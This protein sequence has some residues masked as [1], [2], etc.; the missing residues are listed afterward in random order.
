V[1]TPLYTRTPPDLARAADYGH[2]VC[3]RRPD[4][5]PATAAPL[6]PAANPNTTV[7]NGLDEGDRDWFRPESALPTDPVHVIDACFQAYHKFSLVR[8]IIDLMADFTAKG[9][10]V[11]NR[12]VR[13]QKVGR[14][15]LKRVNARDRSERI[16]H[17]LYLAGTAPLKRRLARLPDGFKPAAVRPVVKSPLPPGQIPVGYDVLDPRTLRLP[18]EF[19]PGQTPDLSGYAVGPPAAGRRLFAWLRPA[20]QRAAVDPAGDAVRLTAKDNV[21][22]FYKRADHQAVPVP[23]TYSVLRDLRTLGKLK[24]ADEMAA[25]GAVTRTRIWTLGKD[26]DDPENIIY[27]TREMMARLNDLVTQSVNGGTLDIIWDPFIDCK[28]ITTDVHHFLGKEKYVPTLEA[29]F[30]GYGVPPT[31]T[32]GTSSGQA[33]F[34]NNAVSMQSLVERLQYVRDVLKGFWEA[35]L[36]LGVRQPLGFR[37][38]FTVVFDGSPLGEDAQLKRLLIELMDREGLSLEFL[39]ERFGAVPEIEQVRLRRERAARERGAAPP[40]AGPFALEYQRDVM[41]ER[42]FVGQGHLTPSQVG[43][44][45]PPPKAGEKTPAEHAAAL[46]PDPADPAD[47]KRRN[48]KKRGTKDPAAYKPPERTGRPP[49]STD[50]VKRRP[51]KVVP[52]GRAAAALAAASEVADEVLKPLYLGALGKATFRQLSTAQVAEYEDLHFAVLAR[53]PAGA[54]EADVLAALEGDL[55]LPDD[56]RAARAALAGLPLAQ[57][58]AGRLALLAA[59]RAGGVED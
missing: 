18:A 9:M 14:E 8:N 35:E 53:L 32:G 55:A 41:N 2:A 23:I 45:Y 42:A 15:W 49:G 7:T 24:L 30:Q 17:M 29:I 31:L 48:R 1:T 59:A 11:L 47:P 25:D 58:R 4:P 16:A 50:K 36:D 56:L 40:K 5:R 27:P 6:F 39:Q 21:L 22:L 19:A 44:D 28:E 43:L 10:D 51:R 20:P 54:G 57:D 3:R 12:G 34:T 26:A 33:G 13:A 46:Q 38:P 52:F 37:H